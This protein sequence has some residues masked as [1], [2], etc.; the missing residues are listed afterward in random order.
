MATT[1]FTAVRRFAGF[2]LTLMLSTLWLSGQAMG[3]GTPLVTATSAVG[4]SHPSGWGTIQQSAIDSAGDWLVVD[5]ANGALYEFPAGGAPAVTLAS[6]SPSASLG[7]GYQNPIVVIDPGNNLYLGAN[8]NNCLVKFA[9]NAA[10]G[11]WTGLND[12]GANDLSPTNPTTTMC[13]NSGS[14]NESEAFAQYGIT[15]N[16]GLE[17]GWFQPWGVAVGNSSNL[18]WGTSNGGAGVAIES[19][20]VTGAWSNPQPS[21][22]TWIP[23]QGM[24]TRAMSVA[25][26]QQG[27]VYFVEDYTC[28]GCSTERLPGVYEIPATATNGQFQSD[29]PV[30]G[31]GK[32]NPP[33]G[34]SCLTRVDP[35]LPNVSGVITDSQGNLYISDT[36]AGVVMVPNPNGTPQ[37]SS[38]V[39]LTSVPAQGEVAFDWARNLMYV[40]TTQKQANGEADVAQVGFGAAEL[41]PSAVGTAVAAGANVVFNFNGAVTPK[42][43]V[44]VEEGASSPDFSIAGGTCAMG[45]P[46]NAGSTCLETVMMT[47]HSVGSVS[48][49]L[50]LQQTQPLPAGQAGASASVTGWSYDGKGNLTLTANNNFVVGQPVD[51]SGAATTG[52][53]APLNGQEFLVQ[54]AS[55]ASFVIETSAVPPCASGTTCADTGN[56]TVTAT[57]EQYVTVASM[58]LHGTGI[59]SL[60]QATP[61]LE[62][63]I[64]GNLVLPSQ[65]AV[66]AQGNV[67]VAD[68]GQGK[69][70]EYPVGS[71]T[72]SAPSSIGSS[73]SAPTGVA[74][75]GAGDVFIADSGTGAVYE[76]PAV[77]S[78]SA[79]E[80][81]VTLVAAGGVGDN[82]RLAADSVGDLYVADPSNKRVVKLRNFNST[83]PLAPSET[84]LTAGFTAPSALAVDSNNNLYIID[85]SN[86]FEMAGGFGNPVTLSSTLPSGANGLAIDTSGAVYVTSPSGT[87]RMANVGGALSGTLAAFPN[88]AASP[89][90]V[91]LDKLGNV[92]LADGGAED[93]HVVQVNGSLI[94]AAFT[95]A[96]QSATLPV[97]VT[98]VGNGALSI[99]GYTATNPTV[100][101]VGVTDWS[102]TDL[103]C[104]G[105][106][107][108]AGN[109]CTFDVNLSPGAGEQGTLTSQIALVSNSQNAPVIDATGTAVSLSG[110]STTVS[111]ATS[112]E[113]INTPI[114]VTIA[115]SSSSGAP[116]TPTGTVALT[117][118]TW[119]VQ[120]VNG[121]PTIVPETQTVTS[122]LNA[123]GQAT[124]TLAPVSAGSDSFAVEYI[125]DRN[126]GRSTQTI[127]APVAKSA[128]TGIALPTFPDPSDIDLPFV[129]AATGQ[130]TTPYDGSAQ[131]FQ[132]NF[133]MNVNTAAGVPTGNIT[134]MD[135]ATACPPGTSATG[136]GAAACILAGYATPSGYSGVACPNDSGIGVPYVINAGTPTGGQATFPTSCLW[137]V[138]QG[139]SYSPVMFTHYI[140][141]VYSGDANFLGLTGGTSTVLQSVRGPMVQITQTG[142]SGSQTAAPTLTL[143][144]GSTASMN[145]TL[146]SMLGYGVSGKNAIDNA[147][148]FPVSLSCDNLPPHAQC[149]FTYPNPDPNIPNA[150]DINCPSSATTTQLADG[151]AQC[152]PAQ[153][154]LTVYS[155]VS[156]GTSVSKNAIGAPMTLAAIFGFGV[157]GLFVRRRAFEKGRM[158]LM[159]F[160]MIVGGGL[161]LSITACSTTTLSSGTVLN[162]PSGSY[163]MTVTATEVGTLCS[164]SQGGA[165]DNCIVPGS[166]STSNNGILVYGSGNQISLPFYV[167]VTVQ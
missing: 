89:T 120:A 30:F 119:I 43:A 50:L 82:L 127:T 12:G 105:G 138:P 137:F 74:V 54:S 163:Q 107:I 63:N 91:A 71:S 38:A 49:S 62:S 149:V 1:S 97:T 10:A 124:F 140:Y 111:A 28:T 164:P 68:A 121:V 58:L 104:E 76:V 57:G 81:Q 125:G 133:V 42:R 34:S 16:T 108:L 123:S 9:W 142:N 109:T 5:Y 114:T 101:T 90:A 80:G 84:M 79:P 157:I 64:G 94:F 55:S 35:N 95:S 103:T 112:A 39:V 98:N 150:V 146:T 130:G 115:P 151:S 53:L 165:G 70:L 37:T 126:Y 48:G 3:Q 102:A 155:N 159:V 67:Y 40:P 36:E 92:Y 25:Q 75:D 118:P 162:T 19:L 143:Q 7:G 61:P 8:Y 13:T 44:I 85:G 11:N 21:A 72:S 161:A 59:G 99:T 129:I 31:N 100:D 128:I 33:T 131:P 167:N 78:L 86:L 152:T 17:G 158:L 77:A 22:F 15:D 52:N 23:I 32:S 41:G 56:D 132:Y 96:N 148:N 135:N 29:C 20:A 134:V 145:L 166:G 106:Q 110:A 116:P 141:P 73:L 18:V 113:V 69:V 153:V 147:T 122:A 66:D 136:V 117:Y 6:A 160:L 139:I 26:D 45:T 87:T 93:V 60:M 83:S 46:Y 14:N 27:N 4:L 156:A 65:V 2:A 47:P 154:T 144:Q 88:A 24:T 51:F